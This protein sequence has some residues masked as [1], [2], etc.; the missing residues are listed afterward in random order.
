MVDGIRVTVT[1]QEA[2]ERFAMP[3]PLI[4]DVHS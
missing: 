3:N 2:L 4:D 1:D